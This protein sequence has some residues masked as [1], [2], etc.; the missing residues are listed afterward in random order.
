MKTRAR[1]PIIKELNYTSEEIAEVKRI[2]ATEVQ[3]KRKDRIRVVLGG[4]L[5]CVCN[6]IPARQITYALDGVRRVETY[7]DKCFT[8]VYE[9]TK[10]FSI[11]TIAERYGCQI[12][13]DNSFGGSKK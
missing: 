13:Q 2:M 6:D 1:A 8:T 10:G 9:M 3:T 4:P 12:A 5:C 7:C 11:N